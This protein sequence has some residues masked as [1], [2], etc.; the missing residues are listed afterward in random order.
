MPLQA[1]E[2]LY[3]ALQ[4]A[5]NAS[6]PELRTAYRQRALQVHPDKGGTA[7]EFRVIVHAFEV[8]VDPAQR[9]SYDRLLTQSNSNDGLRWTKADLPE[10]VQHGKKRKL[11]EEEEDAGIPARKKPHHGSANV[12]DTWRKLKEVFETREDGAWANAISALVA[13]VPHWRV[14]DL[15]KEALIELGGKGS[16]NGAKAEQH[17]DCGDDAADEDMKAL[18]G[19]GSSNIRGVYSRKGGYG[20]TSYFQGLVFLS[21]K[22][23]TLEAAIDVHLS[24]LKLRQLAAAATTAWGDLN[25]AVHDALDR[26]QQ[27]RKTSGTPPLVLAFYVN[28]SC[29]GANVGSPS[30]HRLDTALS[31][32]Q[33]KRRLTPLPNR[34]NLWREAVAGWMREKAVAERQAEMAERHRVKQRPVRFLQ[35]L[36]KAVGQQKRAVAQARGRT[37]RSNA[38]NGKPLPEG[39]QP[40]P[41]REGQRPQLCAVVELDDGASIQG[42]ARPSVAQAQKDFRHL[43]A[44]R[45]KGNDEA[46]RLEAS[47]LDEEVM[48]AL[49]AA[50]LQK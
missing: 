27:E 18:C 13:E 17:D 33:E 50:S 16:A 12:L 49:F 5:R 34:D 42:P 39:V 35:L 14:E 19:V 37:K 45:K 41:W 36:K 20:A 44:L 7:N 43:E 38:F 10:P 48:T 6:D 25:A 47:R 4:V 29:G 22:L 32:L 26:V 30:T 40:V 15:L 28:M 9:A 2:R 8:L 46:V 24:L 3:D 23:D 31:F 1:E 11:E 21:A